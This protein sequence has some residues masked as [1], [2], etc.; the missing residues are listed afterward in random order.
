MATINLLTAMPCPKCAQFQIYKILPAGS[1]SKTI[2][3]ELLT[4]KSSHSSRTPSGI[5]THFNKTLYPPDHLPL[6]HFSAKVVAMN[7]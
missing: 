1:N 6:S 5:G 2:L 4:T 7:D 3:L